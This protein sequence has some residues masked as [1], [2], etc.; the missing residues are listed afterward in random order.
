MKSRLQG[1]GVGEEVEMQSYSTHD[2]AVF[3]SINHRASLPLL[4]SLKPFTVPQGSPLPTSLDRQVS[5]PH[6]FLQSREDESGNT[7]SPKAKEAVIVNF[8]YLLGWA[9]ESRYLVKHYSRRFY[10]D[11]FRCG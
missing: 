3:L 4:C 1:R 2:Q 11:I 5:V 8:V 10:E 7:E 9:T 6:W